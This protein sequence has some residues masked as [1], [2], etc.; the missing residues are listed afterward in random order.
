MKRIIIWFSENYTEIL[1]TS[2][3][4]ILPSILLFFN[5]RVKSLFIRIKD[6]VIHKHRYS[7]KNRTSKNKSSEDTSKEIS[8]E[9]HP[10]LDCAEYDFLYHRICEA[11]PGTSDG[12]T[13]Y[14]DAVFIIKRLKILL[15]KPLTFSDKYQNLGKQPLAWVR[16]DRDMNISNFCVLKKKKILLNRD[17]CIINRI[18]IY[19]DSNLRDRCFVYV[20]CSADKPTGLYKEYDH[21]IDAEIESNGFA[22]EE[23]AIFKKHIITRREFDEQSA[24][25]RKKPTN[26]YG[27]KLRRRFVS[28]YNFMIVVRLYSPYYLSVFF[29]ESES[30]FNAL[31]KKEIEFSEFFEWL[32]KLP[33]NPKKHERY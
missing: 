32:I 19:K 30:Y 1:I 21:L 9:L 27:A 3:G 6:K 15:S 17:E 10:P 2:F 11:F 22:A 31:L 7:R 14:S 8:I 16:G 12:L 20:E 13:E 4:V 29:S 26:T 23:Y 33:A 25:I 28:V 24:L 5:K 18:V